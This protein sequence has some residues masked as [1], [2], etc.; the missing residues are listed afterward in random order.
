MSYLMV[1]EHPSL[2]MCCLA[3][4]LSH[5]SLGQAIYL[6][7][8]GNL[9]GSLEDKLHPSPATINALFGRSL[10]I[11]YLGFPVGT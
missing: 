10:H 5:P 6:A 3:H 8:H 7:L 4:N 11:Q 1:N 2:Y 9:G